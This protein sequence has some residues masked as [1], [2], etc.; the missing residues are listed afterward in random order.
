MPFIAICGGGGKSTIVKKYPH[1]FIDI[2][3]FIWSSENK[4]YHKKLSTALKDEN[5]DSIGNIYQEILSNNKKLQ[6]ENKI[7]LGHHPIN[8]KWI[9]IPHILNIRPIKELHLKNIEKRDDKMRKLAI[10]SWNN[11]NGQKKFEY[12][13]YREFENLLLNIYF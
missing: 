4:S 11:L 9:G 8:A 10:D 2:D 12:K 3:D 5:Y 13:N 1:K 7:I 6:S